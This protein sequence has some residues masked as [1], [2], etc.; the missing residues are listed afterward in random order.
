MFLRMVLG[1]IFLGISYSPNLNFT[2]FYKEVGN[3]TT[4]RH[5]IKINSSIITD[6]YIFFLAYWYYNNHAWYLIQNPST[7]NARSK[8]TTI[9]KYPFSISSGLQILR[10]FFYFILSVIKLHK[11]EKIRKICSFRTKRNISYYIKITF[12][13]QTVLQNNYDY[14]ILFL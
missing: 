5:F 10:N 9:Q 12:C 14:S 4:P 6:S 8:S 2:N 1:F 13:K 7:S 3:K 11:S